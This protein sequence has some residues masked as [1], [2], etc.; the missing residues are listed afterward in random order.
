MAT[1]N[2]A[3]KP[4]P[5]LDFV[6]MPPRIL[7][8]DDEPRML[9]ALSELLR[10][11]NHDVTSV[12]DGTTAIQLLR[13]QSFDLVLLDLNMPGTDGFAVMAHIERNNPQTATIV[14]S[15]D[16]TIDSA[17][18][19]MRQGVHD[20]VRKPY[21]PD[22]LLRTIDQLLAQRQRSKVEQ[23]SSDQIEQS[24]KW[25]R[26]LVNQSPDILYT[27]DT[28][29]RFTF[30]NDRAELFLGMP[31]TELIGRHYTQLVF[32]DDIERAK[33]VLN[34]RRTG[35]R[36]SRDAEVRLKV[37]GTD[38]SV[39]PFLTV[40]V[41]SS[42]I[43][44]QSS[45]GTTA[46]FRGTY[47]VAKEVGDRKRA[48]EN[49]LHQAYHDALTGLPNRLL[50]R[51]RLNIAVVQAKRHGG[52]LAVMFIDLDRFKSINDELGHAAG[53]QLLQAVSA[54]LSKCLRQGD[55]VARLGGDEF[56]L[57]LPNISQRIDAENAARKVLTVLGQPFRIGQQE[58]TTGA[59]IGIAVYPD[60]GDT[61]D[62]LIQNADIA[63][64]DVKAQGRNSF[65]FFSD[66]RHAS[67]SNRVSLGHELRKA[68]GA[69]QLELYYQPQIATVTGEVTG[70]EVLLRWN[71]PVRGQISPEEFI[72]LAQEA[73]TMGY[74]SDWVT[75]SACKQLQ[76]WAEY[77]VAPVRISINLAPEQIQQQDFV[78]KFGEMLR[79]M[80]IDPTLLEIEI[81]ES[82]MM[83]DINSTQ[84]RLKAL[85]DL[86]VQ[87]AIDDF[88][89][90][91]S[92]LS[93]L[94][95]LPVN[96]IKI[97]R[98]FVADIKAGDA[99]TLINAMM[100]IAKGLGL[101]II[102]EGVETADQ[103]AFLKAQGCDEC[104]GYFIS[105]PLTTEQVSRMLVSGGHLPPA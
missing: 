93:Y 79:E 98:T 83:R 100:L 68:I 38:K 101:R 64:Y 9:T 60:D 5:S 57:L 49:I 56:T 80:N 11:R 91:Y 35:K 54:R 84:D 7:V 16:T 31:R 86:G 23:N 46:T 77:G 28:A 30:L 2:L 37:R 53:D 6:R 36:A 58:H 76:E 62:S 87:I 74:L 51:D 90:G 92:S 29:G 19:A 14:V 44:D 27:L 103:W 8:V 22:D 72:P 18:R 47:G 85:R 69:N 67:Y 61:I 66:A 97:D 3:I 52:M 99:N 42:G 43:Y 95:N 13:E 45:I 4:S 12:S 96:A 73:G 50:F 15:G 65:A 88:G 105:K 94:R 39:N 75:R 10:M 102:A 63:M 82:T 81:T 71:H 48:Q 33:F 25:H 17:I 70:L 32:E 21:A 1:N 55:T 104:Q 89:M 59:S 78:L 20:F 26:Y 34:E 40:E 24:E 41:S